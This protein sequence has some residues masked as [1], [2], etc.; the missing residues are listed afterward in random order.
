VREKAQI[1]RANNKYSWATKVAISGKKGSRSAALFHAY[2]FFSVCTRI[3]QSC[4]ASF[5]RS[6]FTSFCKNWEGYV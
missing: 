6:I 5:A 3:I 2:G 4:N 1:V